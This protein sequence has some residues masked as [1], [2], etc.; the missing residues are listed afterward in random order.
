MLDKHFIVLYAK[1]I[2]KQIN[3]SIEQSIEGVRRSIRSFAYDIITKE[4][5]ELN[6]KD[7][8]KLLEAWIPSI[9]RTYLTKSKCINGIPSSMMFEMARQFVKFGIGQMSKKEIEELEEHLG[10]SWSERYWNNFP[11][12]IKR[13]INDFIKNKL[14]FE[15]FNVKLILLLFEK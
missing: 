11:L 3:R 2:E 12:E 6:E 15:I 1:N 7:K 10:A 5:P 13:L 9:S 14:S 8:Q 4:A